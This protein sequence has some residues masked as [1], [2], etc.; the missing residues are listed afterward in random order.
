MHPILFDLGPLPIGTYGLILIVG[1]W[2][3]SLLAR[4]LGVRDGHPPDFISDL[5]FAL[6]ISGVLGAKILLVVVGLLTPLGEAGAI[7]FEEAFPF[8]EPSAEVDV[9]FNGRWGCLMA[10][11]C[12]GTLRSSRFDRRRP[13][14]G[15]LFGTRDWSMGLPDGGVL[16]WYPLRLPFCH[17]LYES[18]CGPVCRD[19]FGYRAASHTTLRQP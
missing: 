8:T 16:L 18:P 10:G 14:G 11:C 15:A 5:T 4:H 12:F 17:Y 13:R 7:T 6:L 9:F 2:A 3:G 19:T 1:F